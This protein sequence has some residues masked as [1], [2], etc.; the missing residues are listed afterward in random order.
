M[1]A[2][3]WGLRE[4]LASLGFGFFLHISLLSPLSSFCSFSLSQ[5]MEQLNQTLND[6]KTMLLEQ[7]NKVLAQNH[8][9]LTRTLDSKDQAMEEERIFK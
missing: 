2:V 1:V 9:L 7:M 5:M 4:T 6:E 3:L 8:E